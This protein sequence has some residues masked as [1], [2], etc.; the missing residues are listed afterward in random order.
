[1]IKVNFKD[2]QWREGLTVQ[3]ILDS[4]GYTFKMLS[5]WV[6]DTPCTADAFKTTLIPDGADVQVIHMISGG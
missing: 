6:N 4:H 5:V 2:T 3:D 1:M